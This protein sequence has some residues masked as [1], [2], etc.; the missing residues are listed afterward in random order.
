MLTAALSAA[1]LTS[2]AQVY[3]VNVVGYVNQTVPANG[4]AILAN[5]LN[6]G[7]NAI[8]DVIKLPDGS[9]GVTIYRYN[10]ATDS[11]RSSIQFITGFGWFSPDGDIAPLAPGEAFF[12][13]NITTAPLTITFVGE[14]PQ[15]QLVNPLLGGKFALK[16]S[17]VPQTARLAAL[18]FPGATG[19]TIYQYNSATQSYKSSYQFIEGFGWFSPDP[20]TDVN[21]PEIPVGTGF[22]IQKAGATVNWSRNFTVN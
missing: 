5:P 4:W 20:D 12:I 19:D 14:V 3:S 21:G 13:N 10:D 11:F 6:N 7:A 22:W 18:E 2:F 1:S 15:G 9:D 17:M 16:S 8:N